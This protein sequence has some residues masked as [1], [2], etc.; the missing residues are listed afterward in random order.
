MY[1][2]GFVR[3]RRCLFVSRVLRILAGCALCLLASGAAPPGPERWEGDIRAFETRDRLAPPPR[4]GIVFVGSSS[5]RLWPLARSFP[6]L[7][8]INRGFGG[9]FVSDSVAFA[10]RIVIPYRPAAVVLYAGDND[11]AAGKTPE[12]VRDDYAAFAR[13]IHGALPAARIAYISIKPSIA[14][15]GLIEKIRAANA[16]IRE[17]AAKDERLFFVDVEPAMLGADGQ[18]RRDLLAEDGLHL[19][20]AGYAAWTKLLAPHLRPRAAPPPASG[21]ESGYRGIWFTLGE[22]SDYGDKYSGGLG[23]YTAKHV[24]LAVYAPEA[25]KTF[26]VY[27]GSREGARGLLAM[28][29]CYDHATG[30]VPR[31]TIVHDKGAV[32]D[33][34]DNPSIALDESGHVWVFVSGRGRSRP[35]FIYRSTAPYDAGEFERVHEGEIT[36]PQPWWVHGRGFVLLFT[37]Y[38]AGRELYWS[39]SPDGRAWAPAR[40]LAGMGGHY[41][42][43]AERNGRIITAFN[44]HPDGSVNRRTN[45]Y[46]ARTDDLGATWRSAGGAVLAPPLVDPAC[47]ALVREF[48]AEGLLVYLKDIAF[49][50]AGNPAILVVTSRDHRPGPAGGPRVWTLL[51]WNGAAWESHEVAR[52]DHNYDMGSLYTEDDAEWRVLAPTEPGP[53]PWGTGGEVALWVSRDRGATWQKRRDVTAGSALNHAYVR[54][55]VNAHP[56][57]YGFWADGDPNGYSCSRLYFTNRAG[58]A[59]RRL[60]CEMEGATAVPERVAGA[61]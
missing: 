33:P 42:V 10:P 59:V 52:S 12:Q 60:P 61:D 30:T 55:P 26:F 48:R 8:A 16:L 49:D 56:D 29:S 32:G 46:F 7:P 20:A 25:G 53:Q 45:L 23:T 47:P 38:T 2:G 24:P 37:K 11:L 14:R 34:H 35:G 41:Q 9:S 58:D 21:R 36:Y 28:A 4:G 57:F 17:A 15:W 50:A 22:F 39:A 51:R 31:P 18:P 5:I 3:D 19:N 13:L 40:K 1:D 54:R 43:S 6:H 44:M 27:G